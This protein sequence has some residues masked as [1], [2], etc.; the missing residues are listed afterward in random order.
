MRTLFA[1]VRKAGNP[2]VA[3]KGC[4]F[5]DSVQA[6]QPTTMAL[7]EDQAI[8]LSKSIAL[9]P[10][11]HLTGFEK[12][13]GITREADILQLG[14]ERSRHPIGAATGPSKVVGGDSGCS[15]GTCLPMRH[16]PI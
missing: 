2:S 10:E 7:N 3:W 15:S 6:D 12:H 14:A 16:S 8:E 9:F 11:F 13:K 4:L 5:S 1:R